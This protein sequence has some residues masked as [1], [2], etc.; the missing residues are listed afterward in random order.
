[1]SLGLG[2]HWLLIG[3]GGFGD[4]DAYLARLEYRW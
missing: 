4:R 1:L 2:E 3:E